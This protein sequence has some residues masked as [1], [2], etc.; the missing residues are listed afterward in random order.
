MA[1]HKGHSFSCSPAWVTGVLGKVYKKQNEI[2]Y[3]DRGASEVEPGK[4]DDGLQHV[5]SLILK[6][7]L[8]FEI[9]WGTSLQSQAGSSETQG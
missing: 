2:S 4:V 9:V 6:P 7:S 8:D 5:A 3:N 1:V